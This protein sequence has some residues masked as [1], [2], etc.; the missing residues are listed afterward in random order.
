LVVLCMLYVVYS[1]KTSGSSKVIYGSDDRLD[2]FEV[3]SSLQ[4]LGESSVLIVFGS[5]IVTSNGDNTFTATSTETAEDFWGFCPSE[6]YSQQLIL[7]EAQAF[8]SGFLLSNDPPWIGTAGHCVGDTD[9]LIIF[10]FEVISSGNTRLTF[11]ADDIYSINRVVVEGNP[12]AAGSDYGIFELDRPVVG[13]NSL[14]QVNDNVSVDDSLILIGHPVGLPK[15]FDSGGRVTGVSSDAIIGTVDAYGGNSGSPVFDS[16]RRLVGILVS[17]APDFDY[18]SCLVSNVCP[19][20]NGCGSGE[21]IVPI[22][23]LLQSTTEVENQ[24]GLCGVAVSTTPTVSRSNIPASQTRTRTP[25]ASPSNAPASQTR[26]R[27]S[28]ISP[29][30]VPADDDDFTTF[31]STDIFSTITSI[32][33]TNDDDDDNDNTSLSTNNNDDDGSS[34]GSIITFYTSMV[35]TIIFLLF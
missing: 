19:G 26:T 13:Y 31:I 34:S 14:T 33:S 21:S 25:T 28:T 4:T 5:N 23:N 3:N 12:Y 9:A 6:R 32:F 2:Y 24:L 29:S 7:S 10:G 11:S 15:K 22:C 27:T 1:H 30:N 35:L 8:C 18:G 20:G 17:G 16:S